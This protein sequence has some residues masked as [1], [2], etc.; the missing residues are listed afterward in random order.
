MTLAA[1]LMVSMAS[2]FESKP[3]L[4]TLMETMASKFESKPLLPTLME[5]MAGRFGSRLEPANHS[6]HQHWQQGHD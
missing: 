4:P 3:L 1:N 6:D 2:K 5:T